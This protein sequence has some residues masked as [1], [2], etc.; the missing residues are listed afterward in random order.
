MNE[1]KFS[2]SSLNRIQC[3]CVWLIHRWSRWLTGQPRLLLYYSALVMTE[4]YGYIQFPEF[5]DIL[6]EHNAS[7]SVNNLNDKHWFSMNN[8]SVIIRTSFKPNGA[9]TTTTNIILTIYYLFI[10]RFSFVSFNE[11]SLCDIIEIYKFRVH[12]IQ[13]VDSDFNEIIRVGVLQN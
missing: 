3:A 1:K 11:Y 7:P 2:D 12:Q 13:S 4:N 10:K 8:L 9:T 6:S 5:D